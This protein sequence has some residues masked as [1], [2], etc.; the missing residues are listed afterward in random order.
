MKDIKILLKKKETESENMA[1]N[2][3]N[4]SQKIKNKSQ[5]SLEKYMKCK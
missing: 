1:M 4:F 3:M 5:L 2:N